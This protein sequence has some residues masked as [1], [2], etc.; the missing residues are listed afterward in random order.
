[1]TPIIPHYHLLISF[2][3]LS[4]I[5][6]KFILLTVCMRLRGYFEEEQQTNKTRHRCT[7]SSVREKI[8]VKPVSF[9]FPRERL[10]KKKKIGLYLR[11]NLKSLSYEMGTFI[12]DDLDI[13]NLPFSNLNENLCKHDKV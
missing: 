13:R 6:L 3:K 5:R 4:T 12:E 8:S 2:V 11:K 7:G 10:I 9:F 1:M